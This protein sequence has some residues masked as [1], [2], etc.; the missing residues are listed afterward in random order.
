MLHIHCAMTVNGTTS[1]MNTIRL[2]RRVK[3]L[4]SRPTCYFIDKRRERARLNSE[5]TANACYKAF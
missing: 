2:L 1:T 4:N 5:C 3:L